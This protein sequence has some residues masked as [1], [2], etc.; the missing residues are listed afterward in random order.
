MGINIE[1]VVGEIPEELKCP[2][3]HDL[4]E[5]PKEIKRCEHAF[6]NNCIRPWIQERDQIYIMT[7]YPLEE[8]SS[9]TVTAC[10]W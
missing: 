5:D 8:K 4:F 7:V 1:L 6:C 3:C 9:P 2:I 10:R